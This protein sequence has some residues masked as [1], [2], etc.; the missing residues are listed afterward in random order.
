[1]E[2]TVKKFQKVKYMKILVLF[3]LILFNLSIYGQ[4]LVSV[5]LFTDWKGKSFPMEDLITIDGDTI[6]KDFFVGKVCVI[7]FFGPGCP[8]CMQE[9][10]YLNK[11][12]NNYLDNKNVCIISF[13]LGTKDSFQKYFK[14]KEFI[15]KAS[16]NSK[17]Q[18]KFSI[19]T[20]PKYAI[21]PIDDNQFHFK[22]HAWGIP[23]NLIITSGYSTPAGVEQLSNPHS[24]LRRAGSIN[25]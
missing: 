16:S 17:L 2:N 1:M 5:V 13:F 24:R 20:V 19:V 4:A 23:S 12:T 15:S 6:K 22:Y 8:P 9:I 7:N 11:L 21:I 18:L 3:I 10:E 25:R 14:S